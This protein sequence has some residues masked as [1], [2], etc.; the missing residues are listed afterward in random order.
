M[1]TIYERYY[2]QCQPAQCTYI[3]DTRNDVI[4]IVTTLF[5]IAGGLTT[6]LKLILPRLIRLIMK[7][8]EEEQQQLVTGKIKSKSMQ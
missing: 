4:Y 5:G 1:S 3:Y 8:K 6:V 7:K 2:N